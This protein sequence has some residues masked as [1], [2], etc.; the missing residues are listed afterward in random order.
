M[1]SELLVA[2]DRFAGRVAELWRTGACV[3]RAAVHAVPA[4]HTHFLV[5]TETGLVRGGWREK[6]LPLV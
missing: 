4:A 1:K 2:P 6:D 3:R 5:S